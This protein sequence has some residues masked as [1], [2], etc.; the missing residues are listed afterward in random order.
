MIG[1]S[2]FDRVMKC[3]CRVSPARIFIDPHRSVVVDDVCI[4]FR[5]DLNG[6]DLGASA[7]YKYVVF[8]FDGERINLL[9]RSKAQKCFGA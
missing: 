3:E 4:W 6:L 2:S 8:P 1:P 5:H 7:L 9:L